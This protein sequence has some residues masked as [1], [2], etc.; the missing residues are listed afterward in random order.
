MGNVDDELGYEKDSINIENQND[1]EDLTSF[2]QNYSKM[3]SEYI[4]ISIL[5]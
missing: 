4:T 1:I 3:K 5:E 2:N